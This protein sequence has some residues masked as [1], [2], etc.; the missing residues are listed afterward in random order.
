M[1][2]QLPLGVVVVVGVSAVLCLL[3]CVSP[4]L[5]L[6]SYYTIIEENNKDTVDEMCTPT[7]QWEVA[8]LMAGLVKKTVWDLSDEEKVKVND[9]LVYSG[10][11]MCSL[12][13][14]LYCLNATLLTRG[15]CKECKNLELDS[16]ESEYGRKL[17]ELNKELCKHAA[18]IAKA[19]PAVKEE[20]PSNKTTT[21]SPCFKNSSPASPFNYIFILETFL[22]I[23]V[24]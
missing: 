12:R 1:S 4:S 3:T 13:K 23:L 10:R 8:R 6:D 14:E 15:V 2:L 24:S 7:N 11:R 18:K 22:V 20:K 5:V 17:K 16:Q 21:P 19:P 9:D